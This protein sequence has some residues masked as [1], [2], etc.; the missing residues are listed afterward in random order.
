[1]TVFNRNI[2]DGDMDGVGDDVMVMTDD[3]STIRA[4]FV[5]GIESSQKHLCSLRQQGRGLDRAVQCLNQEYEYEMLSILN[6]SV[7]FVLDSHPTYDMK[8]TV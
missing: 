2:F 7:S 3:P 4:S 8:T 5:L 1:M 6:F